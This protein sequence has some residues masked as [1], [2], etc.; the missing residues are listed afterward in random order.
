MNDVQPPHDYED[1]REYLNALEW[2]AYADMHVLCR[3]CH[4]TA[5][6]L[7]MVGTAWGLDVTH[8]PGCPD[9]YDDLP[10]PEPLSDC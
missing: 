2:A 5:E 6:L 8:E 1:P 3:H 7:P 9:N 10:A 4:A